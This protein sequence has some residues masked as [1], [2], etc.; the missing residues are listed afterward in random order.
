VRV[1]FCVLAVGAQTSTLSLPL[2][3]ANVIRIDVRSEAGLNQTFTLTVT[4]ATSTNN[5]IQA[6]SAREGGVL[7]ALALSPAVF[8]RTTTNYAVSVPHWRTT[9]DFQFTLDDPYSTATVG[10]VTVTPAPGQPSAWISVNMPLPNPA[11]GTATTS[12][13]I[14]VNSQ[15]G[16]PRQYTVQF[17]TN[18]LPV[19]SLPFSASSQCVSAPFAQINN[20]PTNL[21]TGETRYVIIDMVGTNVDVLHVDVNS[22]R[23]LGGAPN[24][25][26]RYRSLALL[27]YLLLL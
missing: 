14:N 9:V 3:G 21:T 22:L 2:F 19:I 4:R 15:S 1:R 18:A 26:L 27:A 25:F 11:G 24:L 10:G 13:A 17:A 8:V 16:V 5:F 23:G 7:T 12:V 20:N 6:L